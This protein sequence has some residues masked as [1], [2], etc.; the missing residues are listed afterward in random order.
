MPL[1]AARIAGTE[2]TKSENSL[3]P[4][5]G[6]LLS[7]SELIARSGLRGASA[8][9][10]RSY[11]S[12]NMR[13]PS[14]AWIRDQRP[15]PPSALSRC[16]DAGLDPAAWYALVNA[17]VFF[18]LSKARLDRHRSACRGRPQVVLA[19]DLPALLVR[20]GACA[21]VTPFNVGNAR[22]RAAARGRRTFVPLASWLATRWE[23]EAPRGQQI[24]PPSHPPAELTVD[25]S[26]PD[27]IE[28][29][30]DVQWRAAT[31]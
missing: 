7:T 26:V 27:L 8:A 9:K 17:K 24:R 22:R 19:I 16:L 15:M 1:A 25:R 2:R 23:A 4:E 6:G 13:L 11:R 20:Y 28:F 10:F 29:V 5:H 31:P 18:W 14:G 12:E 21:C 3:A 30:I